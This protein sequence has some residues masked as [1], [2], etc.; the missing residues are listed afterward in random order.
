MKRTNLIRLLY[1][2]GWKFE[3]EGG[4]HTVYKKGNVTE[5]IPR[6]KEINERLAKESLN[7]KV[8]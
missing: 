5:E 3:R 8:R 6:H 2:N 7:N 4:S 1:K